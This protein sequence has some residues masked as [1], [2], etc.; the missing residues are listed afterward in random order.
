MEREAS[1]VLGVTT[2]TLQKEFTKS[3]YGM[4]T[5]NS[6]CSFI[7]SEGR[8][9]SLIVKFKHY[10]KHFEFII[11]EFAADPNIKVCL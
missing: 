7:G 10:T 3:S 2:R 9:D 1:H 8:Y 4:S 5:S 6:L 11:Q